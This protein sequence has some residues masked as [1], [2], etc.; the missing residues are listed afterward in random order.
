MDA[1]GNIGDIGG[2]IDRAIAGDVEG[3]GLGGGGCTATQHQCQNQDEDKNGKFGTHWILLLNN[4][5]T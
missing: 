2:Q 1:N 3:A 5:I 4:G